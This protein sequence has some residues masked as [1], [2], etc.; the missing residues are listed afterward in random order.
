MAEARPPRLRLLDILNAIR[1]CELLAARTDIDEQ[2]KRYATE[3]ALEIISEASRHIPD[4]MKS[5]E[6]DIPWINI[7]AFGNVAR[8]GYDQL[9]GE[10]LDDAVRHDLP[11]LKAACERL[12]AQVKRPA[13][14]WPDAS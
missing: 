11:I 2:I 1:M 9:V 13:D 4:S 12:Y 14:P 6:R 8:H 3:R 7:A 10:T 5:Q